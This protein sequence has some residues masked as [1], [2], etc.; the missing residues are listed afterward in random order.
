MKIYRHLLASLFLMAS[1]CGFA[2][3]METAAPVNSLG[4][5]TVNLPYQKHG[6]N[7]KQHIPSKERKLI[8]TLYIK[9]GV[10]SSDDGKAL[11]KLTSLNSLCF[12]FE[13]LPTIRDGRIYKP[14]DRY[15]MGKLSNG[16]GC[17]TKSM[18]TIKEI[19]Y[20][21]N[22]LNAVDFPLRRLDESLT[23]DTIIFPNIERVDFVGPKYYNL[24]E[25]T[26]LPSEIVPI[27]ISPN[28]W[29]IV[30]YP[31]ENKVSLIRVSK[32][33]LYSHPNAI[34]HGSYPSHQQEE[35]LNPANGKLDRDMNAFL[36]GESATRKESPDIVIPSD[37]KYIGPYSFCGNIFDRPRN[38]SQNINPITGNL[39]FK[40][41]GEIYIGEKA[42]Y[43]AFDK[44][45]H[46]IYFNRAAYIC[47]NGIENHDGNFNVTFG[48]GVHLD[49]MSLN[50]LIDRLIFKEADLYCSFD[51][52]KYARYIKFEKSPSNMSNISSGF[53]C[54]SLSYAKDH[55][56]ISM[57]EVPDDDIEAFQ[58]N[59]FDP[60]IKT[61]TP[62]VVEVKQ[63]GT[64]LAC[65]SEAELKQ[66]RSLAIIGCLDDND[67]KV[68]STLGEKLTRLDLSLAF[69]SLSKQTREDREADAAIFGALFGLM[70]EQADNLYNDFRLSTNDYKSV[71]SFSS[72]V[73]QAA[74]EVKHSEKNCI[75]P[76]GCFKD[77]PKLQV[78]ILPVWCNEIERN[79]FWNCQRL[80]EVILPDHIEKI[81]QGAFGLC[82]MLKKINFPS[83]ITEIAP[84]NKK[85]L[86]NEYQSASAFDQCTSLRIVDLSSCKWTERNWALMFY[87][88]KISLLKLPKNLKYFY[89]GSAQTIYANEGIQ[90]FDVKGPST[91]YFKD[92]TPPKFIGNE[93]DLKGCTLYVPIGSKPAY[94]AKYGHYCKIIEY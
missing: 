26:H 41:G 5:K 36:N 14:E 82:K 18:P 50:I 86:Y 54:T 88:C 65:I 90:T 38:V 79:A 32:I 63:A 25:D 91:I 89:G 33:H 10:L 15:I 44:T 87:D 49:R 6:E 85:A 69:T 11:E 8:T 34:V 45:T 80:E 56:L 21:V 43:D 12:D 74:S 93:G 2:K 1:F 68:I 67:L 24:T 16:Y 64:L 19:S 28:G 52:I 47:E 23:G 61:L 94:Y 51:A 77:M 73:Q 62:K 78:V 81:G 92:T 31:K 29:S 22:D 4:W 27:H 66:L 7:L 71:K 60:E 57:L 46:S 20:F 48:N 39:T 35:A 53:L 3:N 76:N 58:K 17:L 70:A 55:R 13:S 40:A 84:A 59:G 37:I 83:T 30:I 42:Y 72:M 9:S 75:I